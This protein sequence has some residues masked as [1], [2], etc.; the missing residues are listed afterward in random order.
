[1]SQSNVPTPF[2]GFNSTFNKKTK[3]ELPHLQYFLN[4]TY[5]TYTVRNTSRLQGRGLPQNGLAA[6]T[7]KS[8][9]PG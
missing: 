5:T 6:R 8:L 9:L 3:L 2:W 1:M 4:I 7:L